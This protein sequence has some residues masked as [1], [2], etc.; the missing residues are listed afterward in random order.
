M[1]KLLL[2]SLLAT[3]FALPAFAQSQSS[4]Y[5]TDSAKS[6]VKSG[7]GLCWMTSGTK[8]PNEACGDEVEFVEKVNMRPESEVNAVEKEVVTKVVPTKIKIVEKIMINA[9][10]LFKFDSSILSAKGM[11]ALD[12]KVVSVKPIKIEVNGHTDS[13]GTDSYNLDL[14]KRRANAVR[15]Y[16]VK[17]DISEESISINAFGETQ[18]LCKEKTKTC[19]AENRRVE[20]LS[21]FFK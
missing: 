13:T 3:M 19:N 20:I 17:K 5:L 16:L 8:I 4:A 11:E 14:S 1:K 12:Q 15:D 10:V 21:E 7:S 2:S 6:V 18:L 9:S